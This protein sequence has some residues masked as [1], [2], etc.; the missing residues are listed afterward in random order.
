MRQILDNRA[1][2][3]LAVLPAMFGMGAPPN[4]LFIVVT[5]FLSLPP[6]P[7]PSPPTRPPAHPPTHPTAPRARAFARA[8]VACVAWRAWR[9][10][11]GGAG[12]KW[13]VA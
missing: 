8:C 12:C 1:L 3:A 13:C 6:S 10:R 11:R 4:I 2:V 7:H 9:G 5:P